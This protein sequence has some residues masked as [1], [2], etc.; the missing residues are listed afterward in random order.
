[1][2][3]AD[4]EREK[5]T[6]EAI[7]EA[8]VTE[9]S[10]DLPSMQLP[11]EEQSMETV[12][13]VLIDQGDNSSW[14]DEEQSNQEDYPGEE[15]LSVHDDHQEHEDAQSYPDH[16]LEE[17][18]DNNEIST[19]E[20]LAACK[21]S[22]AALQDLLLRIRAV[23]D[24]QR[25]LPVQSGMDYLLASSFTA[26]V[27]QMADYFPSGISKDE[28]GSLAETS[29]TCDLY[30]GVCVANISAAEAAKGWTMDLSRGIDTSWKNFAL[31]VMIL[32]GLLHLPS[33]N[34]SSLI[35]KTIVDQVCYSK[36][37]ATL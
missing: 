1:M 31:Q 6:M 19:T 25:V 14:E 10:G 27:L 12:G 20:I 21:E 32:P 16:I 18:L 2:S 23:P 35:G 11:V 7:E 17:P 29:T 33:L 5:T 4:A 9:I 3:Q 15:D 30:L 26:K 37:F 24:A 34:L 22:L 28:L 36:I 13:S 8:K